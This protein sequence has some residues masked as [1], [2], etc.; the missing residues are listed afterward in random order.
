MNFQNINLNNLRVFEAVY[1]L[2]CMTTASKE[3]HLTQSGVSQHIKN[4]ENSLDIKLFDRVKKTILPTDQGDKL[5][6]QVEQGLNLLQ[7]SLSSVG[8]QGSQ[9]QGAVNIGMPIEFGINLVIPKLI[10]IGN[11]FPGIHYKI[12]LGF[13]KDMNELLLSG[14]LDIAIVDDYKMDNR[15]EVNKLTEETLHMCCTE[16]YLKTKGLKK[17]LTKKFYESLD[18]VAY[19]DGQVVLRAWLNHHIKR[20]NL[21]L[22]AKVQVMDVQAVSRFI[23]NHYAVGV[24]PGQ[25]VKLLKKNGHKI[26]Q[27]PESKKVLSNSLSLAFIENRTHSRQVKTVIEELLSV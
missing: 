14:Q 21:E 20:K 15:V 22:T 11:K 10:E 24:L 2:R 8:E 3:L 19:Q 13:A 4:L 17:T 26:V 16:K 9:I 12:L 25:M 23:T 7:D 6:V 5:Y 1:R 27:L 18:Y